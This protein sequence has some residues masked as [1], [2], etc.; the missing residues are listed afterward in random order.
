M[1]IEQR[2]QGD[3]GGGDGIVE[4]SRDRQER[5][6]N[7]NLVEGESELHNFCVD[8]LEELIFFNFQRISNELV[9]DDNYC[10]T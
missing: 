3:G 1:Q 9:N 2:K 10:F 7:E 4:W 8:F 6:R 5:C